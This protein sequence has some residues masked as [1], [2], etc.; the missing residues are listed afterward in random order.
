MPIAERFTKPWARV[1]TARSRT[2]LSPA[3]FAEPALPASHTVVTPLELHKRSVFSPMS[4]QL[5]KTCA[6]TATS[7]GVTSR[8]WALMF[9]QASSLRSEPATSTI[10]PPIPT[11]MRPR[12]RLPGSITSPS[13]INKSYFMIAN[14][15][16]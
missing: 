12:S 13:L 14:P 11:S 15:R 1:R 3:K 4:E 5:A 7:P 9:L 6:W 10:L 8:P 2:N 16:H